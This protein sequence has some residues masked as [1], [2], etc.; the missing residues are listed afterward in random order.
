MLWMVIT[1]S[2]M[3]AGQQQEQTRI[4]FYLLVETDFHSNTKHRWKKGHQLLLKG[5][6]IPAFIQEERALASSF[7]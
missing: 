1:F 5:V 7:F 6:I 2:S 4:V 3:A